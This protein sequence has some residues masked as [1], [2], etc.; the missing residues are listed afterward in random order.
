[1]NGFEINSVR[2]LCLLLSLCLTP[3]AF[4]AQEIMKPAGLIS[5]DGRMAPALKLAD[6]DGKFVDLS[7]LK[8]QWILV[9]FW[10]TWCG[11]CRREMP[12]LQ[13]LHSKMK[14]TRFSLILVNTAETDDEVFSF[15]PT[16]APDL[17]TLMD[18]DGL[19]TERWQPRGLPSS[20]IVDPEGRLRYLALGGRDWASAEYVAF[21][22]GLISR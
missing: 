10:A 6:M 3:A 12:T 7:A 21:L 14:D 4:G 20:Y 9:H 17:N 1:M 2:G 18:R 22:N 5:L 8:G 19:A 15:M 16:V 13:V 11:P